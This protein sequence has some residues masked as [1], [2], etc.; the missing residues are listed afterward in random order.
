MK[1][2]LLSLV[3]LAMSCAVFTA[4]STVVD[5]VFTPTAVVASGEYNEPRNNSYEVMKAMY[6]ANGLHFQDPR[7]PRF[8]FLDRKGRVAL[9]IGGYVK[10]TMSVDMGGISD[11][12]DFVVNKIPTPPQPDMRN[13]FQMDAST[14]R[15]FFK[16]V[17]RNTAVGDFSIYIET[18]FRGTTAGY[19]GM[20]LR[21]AYVQLWRL[22]IGRAWS[23]FTDV[24]TIPPTID[25]QGPCGNTISMNTMLQ[26]VQPIGNHWSTAI[27]VEAAP[28]TYTTQQTYN[29][30]INPRVPD[31]PSYV[32]YQWNDGNSHIRWSNLLRVLS[33]RNL[34]TDENKYV[35][36]W[37]TQLSSVIEASSHFTIYLQGSYGKGYATYLNDL[38]GNGFDLIPGETDGVLVAPYAMGIVGGVKYSINHAIFVSAAYSR[39]CLYDEPSLAST[40]YHYGQYVV[41]NAFYTPFNNCQI[42]LEYLYGNRRNYNGDSG[43][44]HRINAMIQY[45]F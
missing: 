44:A 21:K 37:A 32:Q 1:K 22:R 10:G 13:Q 41:A 7:A 8:L 42:G 30:Y 39:C 15:L 38:G 4:A 11:S 35:A 23:T 16:L 33:Y 18:D 26:Y 20:Q 25:N 29:R 9:G 12:P 43:D 14:S 24:V 3:L 31:I 19:Y 6:E 40:A 36:G 45:N 28:V 17:G 5:S 27:A 34:V 2:N